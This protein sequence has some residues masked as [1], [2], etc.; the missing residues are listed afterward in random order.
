MDDLERT[1]TP[2]EAAEEF[3]FAPS[4]LRRY[5]GIYESLG[6]TIATDKR[7][8]RIYSAELL[9]HFS[10]ARKRVQQ[11]ERVEDALKTLDLA[12]PD[13]E[14]DTYGMVSAEQVLGVLEA[15][16]D[17]NRELRDELSSLRREVAELS[18]RQ[19]E[20]PRDNSETELERTNRYLLGELERRRLE[21]EQKAQ[22]RPW[23]QLWGR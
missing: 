23:W 12:P 21:A 14:Q 18:L 16:R 10:A 5:A 4:L 7:G 3:G 19:L 11:G 2:S 9:K 17:S 6:G 20:A 1:L 13:H 22:R 15:L 8:G